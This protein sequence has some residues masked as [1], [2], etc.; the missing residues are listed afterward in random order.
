MIF[1]LCTD[2]LFYSNDLLCTNKMVCT[3][4]QQSDVPQVHTQPRHGPQTSLDQ[5]YFKT[6]YL[7][8]NGTFYVILNDSLLKEGHVLFRSLM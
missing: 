5:T 4:P 6:T 7:R 1:M 8:F 2:D 3:I